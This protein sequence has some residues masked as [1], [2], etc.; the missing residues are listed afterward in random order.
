V[1]G[2]LWGGSGLVQANGFWPLRR[3][4]SLI[5][6]IQFPINTKVERKLEKIFGGFRKYGNFS[7][8]RSGHLGQFWLLTP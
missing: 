5:L 2:R 1:D 6:Y 7:G 8:G 4:G 3:K